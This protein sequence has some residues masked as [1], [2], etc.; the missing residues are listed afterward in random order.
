MYFF[1]LILFGRP[2][3]L[4]SD[5]YHATNR[6]DLSLDKRQNCIVKYFTCNLQRGIYKIEKSCEESRDRKNLI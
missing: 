2:R 4:I 5:R 3:F 6:A 1:F